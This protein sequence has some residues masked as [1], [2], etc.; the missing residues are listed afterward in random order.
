MTYF[1]EP[2]ATVYRDVL[3]NMAEARTKK[4]RLQAGHKAS[5][6]KLHHLIP[7]NYDYSILSSRKN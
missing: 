1:A 4:K 5:A 7:P 6:T 2:E 3:S